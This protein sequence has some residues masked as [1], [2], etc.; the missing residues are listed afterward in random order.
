MAVMEAQRVAEQTQ[1]K[2][3]QQIPAWRKGDDDWVLFNGHVVSSNTAETTVQADDSTQSII[4]F[5]ATDV[6]LSGF[7]VHIRLGAKARFLRLPR[8]K[9]KPASGDV[10]RGTGTMCTGNVQFCCDDGDT[11]GDCTGEWSCP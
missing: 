8:A 10:C 9:R 11:L 7:A 1:Q 2:Q 5:D 4:S 3:E 6:K